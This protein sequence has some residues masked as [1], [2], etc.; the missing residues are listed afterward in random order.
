MKDFRCMSIDKIIVKNL[1]ERLEGMLAST[2]STNLNAFI[3]GGSIIDP[4]LA[5]CK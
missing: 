3:E 1:A 2:I 5:A 4:T